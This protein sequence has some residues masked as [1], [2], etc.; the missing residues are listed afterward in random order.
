[1]ARRE[2]G[3]D[4]EMT[5]KQMSYEIQ[6]LMMALGPEEFMKVF[7]R[8]LLGWM[9]AL[10]EGKRKQKLLQDL[11]PTLPPAAREILSR[12]TGF[13]FQAASLAG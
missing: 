10:P 8:S 1:M 5:A 4:K 13:R 3:Q 2:Q 9:K 7:E 11:Y 12:E 6:R